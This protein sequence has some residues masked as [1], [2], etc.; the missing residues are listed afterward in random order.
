MIS[1]IAVT[2]VHRGNGTV[3]ECGESRYFWNEWG[4]LQCCPDNCSAGC[5]G[6]SLQRCFV[7]MFYG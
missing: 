2:K 3:T 7:R 5:D 1:V 4:V 6:N